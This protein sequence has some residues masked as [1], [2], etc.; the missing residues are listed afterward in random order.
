[1]A[2]SCHPNVGSV[3]QLIQS[4]GLKPRQVRQGHR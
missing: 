4:S 1:M 3:L 2:F